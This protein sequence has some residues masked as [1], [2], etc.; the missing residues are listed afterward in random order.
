MPSRV[1]DLTSDLL[2]AQRRLEKLR[3]EY[4]E[5][6][7]SSNLPFDETAVP[8]PIPPSPRTLPPHLGWHS[9]PVTALLQTA[10]SPTPAPY[11]QERTPAQSV[12]DDTY[13]LEQIPPRASTLDVYPD[14]A[15]GLLQHDLAA[16]GRIWF[17]LRAMDINGCG[18][19]AKAEA[20]T[21]L[22][23]KS[24]DLRVCGQRQLRN[25]LAKGEDVFWMRVNGRIWLR[26]LVKVASAIGVERLRA[27]PVLLP[28]GILTQ[29]I[30]TVRA[31]LYATFHS[32]RGGNTRNQKEANP[33][34]RATI[35]KITH[36]QPRIQ[37]LYEKTAHV[38]RHRHFGIGAAFSKSA[39]EESRWQ[40][41]R[42]VF[43]LTDR[44]GRQGTPGQKYLAWQLPNSYS[45]PHKVLHGARCKRDNL[46]LT[47]LLRQ[48]TTG[49]GQLEMPNNALWEESGRRYCENGRI[50]T[51]KLSKHPSGEIYWPNQ[52]GSGQ[53]QIWHQ[54]PSID[55]R[56][57]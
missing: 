18:W 51:K 46:K 45:G 30:G 8:P 4:R 20:I 6:C 3:H 54:L 50:A 23:D 53:V 39:A 2:L 15:I 14:I 16:V 38:K 24:S 31:H 44:C 32:S 48:G 47:D 5:N 19:V 11:F 25:L 26:S 52:A 40:H 13:P 37:R 41:G 55:E 27:K 49:N 22:T 9:Q 7:Q 35:E 34:A 17:L 10:V 43:E 36:V 56:N 42:A 33:I 12:I 1:Q 57:K 28:V 21:Q 29:R